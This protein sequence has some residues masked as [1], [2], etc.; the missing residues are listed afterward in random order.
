MSESEDLD[1]DIDELLQDFESKNERTILHCV[2][3]Y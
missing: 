2:F 3:F 1:N